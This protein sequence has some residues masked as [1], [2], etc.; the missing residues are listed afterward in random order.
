M[1]VIVG[2]TN[3]YIESILWKVLLGSKT[4]S[5]SGED[6]EGSESRK[7]KITTDEN[8]VDNASNSNQMQFVDHPI[9]R[10]MEESGGLFKETD[11]SNLT[12][13]ELYTALHIVDPERTTKLHPNDRRKILRSLQVRFQTGRKHSELIAEQCAPLAHENSKGKSTSSNL[14]TPIQQDSESIGDKKFPDSLTTCLGGP[15]RFTDSFCLWIKVDKQI[16]DNRIEARV[17]EMIGR[18]LKKELDDFMDDLRALNR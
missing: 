4:G 5:G 12:N 11:V 17:E 8:S 13:Q 14:N 6:G 18:G 15:L 2:G 16:L 3:Y 9:L 7:R 10:F 1:P